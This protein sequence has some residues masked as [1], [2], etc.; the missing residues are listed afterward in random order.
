MALVPACC[1]LPALLISMTFLFSRWHANVD[2]FV[3]RRLSL[4]RSCSSASMMKKVIMKAAVERRGY[5]TQLSQGALGVLGIGVATDR[6]EAYE[7]SRR[8]RCS[9]LKYKNDIRAF[10]VSSIVLE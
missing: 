4:P 6:V 3:P 1:R 8:T 9:M 10:W 5:I 7:V 2:A